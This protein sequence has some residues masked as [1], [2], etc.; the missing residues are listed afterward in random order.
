MA[1]SSRWVSSA[2]TLQARHRVGR[3]VGDRAQ[4]GQ[5]HLTH[6]VHR[7][8]GQ[9]AERS[10][11]LL[12]VRAAAEEGHGDRREALA[13]DGL[14]DLGQGRELVG[15]VPDGELVRGFLGDRLEGAEHVAHLLD[16]PQH[17]AAVHLRCGVQ[18][19]LHPGD[20][21]EVA[22]A[23]AHGPEQLRVLGRADPPQ[24]AEPVDELDGDDAVGAEAVRAAEPA[25]A[26]GDGHADHGRV[27]VRAGQEGQAG[28]VELGEQ[29]A[30]L[31]ARADPRRTPL[32]VDRDAAQAAGAE[33]QHLVEGVARAVAG[34]LRGDLHAVV[35]GPPDRC[36]DVVG[37]ADLEHRHRVLG[38]VHDPGGAGGVPGLVGGGVQ[39]ADH[40]APEVLQRVGLVGAAA[41]GGLGGGWAGIGRGRVSDIGVPLVT[42]ARRVNR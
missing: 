40:P 7:Q 19:D 3:L 20:D 9:G 11:Q 35:D 32:H 1:S 17:P 24:A 8:P 37:V 4:L 34:R 2:G 22:A 38:D 28:A 31:D 18:R 13:A 6:Q 16:R 10:Q 36:G 27:G 41:G 23:S 42:S 15:V 29:L 26:A 30:V 33:H 25:D 12:G 14:G 39:P 5:R 21:P